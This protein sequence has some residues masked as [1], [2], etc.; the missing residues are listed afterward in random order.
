MADRVRWTATEC[1]EKPNELDRERRLYLRWDVWEERD[2]VPFS[3]RN[4]EFR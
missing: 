1:G 3:Q 4:L 2:L